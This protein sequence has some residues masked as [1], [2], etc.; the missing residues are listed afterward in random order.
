MF[1]YLIVILC[2]NICLS[3]GQKV[4]ETVDCGRRRVTENTP[5]IG[6][7]IVFGYDTNPGKWPWHVAVFRVNETSSSYSCGGTLINTRYR[8][9]NMVKNHKL[10]N[11]LKDQIIAFLGPF[12]CVCFWLNYVPTILTTERKV[13]EP[14]VLYK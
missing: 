13:L 3:M 6:N 10:E 2:L 14:N 5:L 4:K 9:Y 1:V 7:R 8:N 12:I 11:G